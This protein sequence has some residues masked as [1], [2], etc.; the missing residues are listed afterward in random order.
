MY[1]HLFKPIIDY[2]IGW[3]G[4]LLC[5]PLVGVIAIALAFDFRGN[6]FFVQDRVG[7]DGKIFKIFKLRTMKSD[8]NQYG[9]LLPDH[10][11]LTFLGRWLRK[12]SLDELPQFLNVALGHMS[13]IGPRPLLV[14]YLPLYTKKEARR[15]AVKPGITGLAQVS[16]RNAI[17]WREKFAYDIE[18]VSKV[19]FKQD[20]NIFI[21]SLSKPFDESGIYN[22]E[23]HVSPFRGHH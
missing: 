16:G 10:V 21:Q 2:L 18:Y 20:L 6:P 1:R 8:V 19:T 4:V 13:L 3:I 23:E 17:S 12:T 9:V 15:H 11:R 7:K 5:L 22:D 14:E